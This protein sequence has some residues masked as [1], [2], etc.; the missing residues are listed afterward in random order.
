AFYAQDISTHDEPTEE[1]KIQSRDDI[2][3]TYLNLTYILIYSFLAGVIL[4]RYFG[5]SAWIKAVFTA[6]VLLS[7]CAGSSAAAL[8]RRSLMAHIY[9]EIAY[10]FLFLVYFIIIHSFHSS[11]QWFS[12]IM[13]FVPAAVIFG[14]AIYH[15]VRCIAEEN[16]QEGG[17]RVLSISI[18]IIPVPILIALSLVNFTE[19]IFSL[20]FYLLAAVNLIIPGIYLSQKKVREYKKGIYFIFAALTVPLFIFLHF[21][22]TIPFSG[23][24][25]VSRVSGYDEILKINYSADYLPQSA[26]VSLNGK[27][28][29]H[30][31]DLSIRSMKRQIITLA[32]FADPAS[33]NVLFVDG[34]RRFFANPAEGYFSGAVRFDYFPDS[35]T[36]IVKL[37]PATMKEIPNIKGEIIESFR[38]SKA[39]FSVI[40]DIPNLYDQSFSQWRFSPDYYR[41]VKKHLTGKRI[42]AQCFDISRCSRS[43]FSDAIDS[44]KKEFPKASAFLYANHLIII[45]SDRN[46]SIILT[47]EG[48]QRVRRIIQTEPGASTVFFSEIQ[49]ISHALF[50]DLSECNA[51]PV[52]RNPARDFF[53]LN[54][55]EGTVIPD[56]LSSR[57]AAYHTAAVPLAADPTGWVFKNYLEQSLRGYSRQLTLLKRIEEFSRAGDY[58]NETAALLELR[59][60]GE[61]DQ[62]LRQYSS[63]LLSFKETHYSEMALSF[64]KNKKW[65]D[66]G[67]IYR[68][69][70]IINPNSFTANYRMSLISLTLQDIDGAF[71]Y[72]RTAMRL[73][74]D[75]PNVMHQMGV[76][77]FSTRKY[78]EALEYLQKAVLLKKYD[79]ATYYYIGLCYEEM[80]RTPEAINY[81]QQSLVKDPE[82]QE[83]SGSLQRIKDKMQKTQEQWQSPEKKNQYDVERGE[84]IPLPINKSAIDIRLKDED[85]GQADSAAPQ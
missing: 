25:F 28:V 59:R 36:G 44:F 51:V 72:L 30:A 64:E 58:E 12:A 24:S 42:F 16:D 4:N 21:Y 17:F 66:A 65:E 48:L 77:L 71:G 22:F 18:F 7:F 73:Q 43:D 31:D 35:W 52:K 83:I 70:L 38:R 74:S 5:D 19:T 34:T 80:G 49:C 54:S 56:D 78:S 15:S 46:D 55:A 27:P 84:E 81:Y 3:F 39:P 40:V 50:S 20:F 11:M 62:S 29:F 82:N 14:G 57:F 13:L 33:D 37:P 69:I 2:F 41:L 61:Y 1:E 45:G 85:P 63:A 79:A 76:L 10:P 67:K 9:G 8:I 32:L 26:D 68:A 6:A 75:N 53:M 23:R 60:F 47:A